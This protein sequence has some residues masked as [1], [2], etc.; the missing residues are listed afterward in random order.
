MKKILLLT[1]SLGLFAGSVFA[2]ETTPPCCE[3]GKPAQ[4]ASENGDAPK[5]GPCP[6]EGG[7]C[8]KFGTDECK[9]RGG[10]CDDMK[11]DCPFDGDGANAPCADCTDPGK[12]EDAAKCANG[13]MP[14]CDKMGDKGGCDMMGKAKSD[15]GMDKCD[16]AA[17]CDSMG[18]GDCDMMGGKPPCDMKGKAGCDMM[19]KAKSDC[20]MDKCDD[21]EDCGDAASCDSMGKGACDMMGKGP[22]MGMKMGKGGC[23]K[24]GMRGGGGPHMMMMGG[25]H[26]MPHGNGQMMVKVMTMDKDGNMVEMSDDMDLGL[27]IDVDLEGMEFDWAPGMM[28]GGPSHFTEMEERI[29]RLEEQ[30]NRIEDLLN[31]IANN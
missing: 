20:D 29:S 12:C 24:M 9:I 3:E 1:L 22:M 25:G 7:E 23:D 26:G 31:Q 5:S 11:G 18:K 13:E 17:S 14:D 28:M 21:M 10:E 6:M 4:E 2:Q 19:G 27:G 16:D 8:D 30:L 15:C